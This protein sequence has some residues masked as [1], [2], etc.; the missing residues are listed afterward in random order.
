M[1]NISYRKKINLNKNIL[2]HHLHFDTSVATKRIPRNLF[3]TYKSREK[4]LKIWM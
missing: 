2:L 4:I 3:Q 1:E